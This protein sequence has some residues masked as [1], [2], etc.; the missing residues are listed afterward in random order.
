MK[1]AIS[2]MFKSV[3]VSSL[4]VAVQLV[5]AACIGLLFVSIVVHIVAL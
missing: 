4:V 1:T 5:I 3:V 2:N